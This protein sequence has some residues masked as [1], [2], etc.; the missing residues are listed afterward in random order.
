MEPTVATSRV[1]KLLMCPIN[2][3]YAL[4]LYSITRAAMI[5]TSFEACLVTKSTTAINGPSISSHSSPARYE[6]II[7]QKTLSI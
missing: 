6:R 7:K 5:Y 2:N 3:Y 1:V 4:G